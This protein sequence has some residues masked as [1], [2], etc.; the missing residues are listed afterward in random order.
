[1]NLNLKAVYVCVTNA[2]RWGKGYTIE[3]AKAAAGLPKT[4]KGTQYYVQAA[5]FDDPTDSELAN[6]K[7][8][9][10]VNPIDGS[11]CFYSDKRLKEDTEMIKDKHVGWIIIEKNYA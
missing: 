10:N 8:C 11:P 7:D 4:E 5:M 6:L 9:I 2:H 3:A 1:M